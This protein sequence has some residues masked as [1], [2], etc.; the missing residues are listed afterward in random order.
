MGDWSQI[1]IFV[2]VRGRLY[3]IELLWAMADLSSSG[4]SGV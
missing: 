1:L 3:V 4:A 2:T